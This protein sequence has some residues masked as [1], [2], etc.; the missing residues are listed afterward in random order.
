MRLS[1]IEGWGGGGSKAR[2]L[3]PE[4][5]LFLMH[6]KL[7]PHEFVNQMS[8]H[9]NGSLT[10]MDARFQ[11]AL[12]TFDLLSSV[13]AQGGFVKAPG[14]CCWLSGHPDRRCRVSGIIPHL[15]SD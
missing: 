5:A 14:V 11:A 13:K 2:G 15:G 4:T 10:R 9:E 1:W 3:S 8:G 7:V 6:K 12:N